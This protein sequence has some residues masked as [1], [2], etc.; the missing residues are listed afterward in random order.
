MSRS[1]TCSVL[2]ELPATREPGCMEH[3]TSLEGAEDETSFGSFG[4]TYSLLSGSGRVDLGVVTLPVAMRRSGEPESG[5][6]TVSSGPNP[7]VTTLQR[8]TNRDPFI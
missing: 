7:L 2:V 8:E 6:Q 5:P 4:S 1:R 3:I